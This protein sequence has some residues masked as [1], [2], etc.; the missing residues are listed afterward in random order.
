MQDN[1]MLIN[2]IIKGDTLTLKNFYKDTMVYIK[3]YILENSGNT[4]DVEDVFQDGLILLYQKLKADVLELKVPIKTYF[5]AICKNIWRNKM[6][7]KAKLILTDTLCY[8]EKRSDTT[9][10]E[11]IENNEQEYLYK[12][13]F[14][15]LSPDKRNILKLFFEGKS[16]KEI[17]ATTGYSEQYVRKKKFEIKKELMIRIEQDPYY[18]ELKIV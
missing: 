9:L 1:A 10:L 6:R 12:K 8:F 15:Q 4:E 11:T 2:G 14:Q 5:Y 7:K 18:K 13:H 16:M 3:R 17:A